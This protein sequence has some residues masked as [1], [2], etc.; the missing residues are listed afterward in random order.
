MPPIQIKKLEF[1]IL[2]CLLFMMQ[3]AVIES[4]SATLA[5]ASAF[6]ASALRTAADLISR[7][8]H[9]IVIPFLIGT[10]G[11]G[12]VGVMKSHYPERGGGL[13]V[14]F[15]I[16]ADYGDRYLLRVPCSV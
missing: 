12:A 8:S 6:Q 9:P 13:F 11:D 15:E 7:W 10:H 16:G 2:K 5:D 14:V 1:K 4:H 3:L